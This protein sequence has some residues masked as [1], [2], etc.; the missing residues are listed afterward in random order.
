ME[1]RYKSDLYASYMQIHIPGKVNRKQ[2][3]F[4]MLEENRIKGILSAKERLEEGEAY[5][6]LDI[7]GRKSLQQEYQDKELTLEDMTRLFQQLAAIFDELRNYLLSHRSVLLKPEYLYLDIET[8]ELEVALL[9]WE[10]EAEEGLRHLAEFFLEKMNQRDEHGINA[11]YLFYKQQSQ[12][13][14]SLCQFLATIEKENILKRQKKKE[15][16]YG[17]HSSEE[18]SGLEISFPEMED[19]GEGT[20][21]TG[22]L[23]LETEERRGKKRKGIRGLWDRLFRKRKKALSETDFSLSDYTIKSQ[24]EEYPACQ[25]TIFFESQEEGWKLQWKERG[26][27]KTAS[28]ETLPVTV[29]KIREEVSIVMADSSVSR[30]HCRFVEQDGGIAVMDM[31]STNGTVLNGM[32]L[33][34][35]E[36]MGI[37]KNDEILIGKV[38]VLVV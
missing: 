24:E 12:P 22:I 9:P 8:K 28:L 29:G 38:R 6:C 23:S 21:Q 37:T 30:I 19:E 4:Q 14:F 17:L 1:V 3:A 5:L 16:I 15:E 26:R 34:P 35:G 11:A 20:G 27:T 31:N 33:R 13:N 25:E 36:I 32:R 2:Y 18:K 7:T 10:R